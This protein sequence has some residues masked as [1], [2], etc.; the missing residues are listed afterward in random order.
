[1]NNNNNIIPNSNTVLWLHDRNSVRT[2]YSVVSSQ[3]SDLKQCVGKTV[4]FFFSCLAQSRVPIASEERTC[5]CCARACASCALRHAATLTRHVNSALRDEYAMLD[6][7]AYVI[8]NF[9]SY[10]RK[11]VATP[12]RIVR[13]IYSWKIPLPPTS[14]S[15]SAGQLIQ[16]TL[17]IQWNRFIWS[18]VRGC[19][20][21]NLSYVWCQDTVAPPRYFKLWKQ[22]EVQGKVP[23][24]KIWVS[25]P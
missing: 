8:Q 24:K 3:T 7:I 14:L 1:M 12:P 22:K 6:C 17:I 5:L 9:H 15:F 20:F 18:T 25:A 19:C 2:W 16:T 13:H 21:A 10:S 11:L 4:L 23:D